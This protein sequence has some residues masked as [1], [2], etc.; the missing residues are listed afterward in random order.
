MLEAFEWNVPADQQHWQRL[1]R[2]LS[3]LKATGV[4]NLWLPPGCKASSPDCN[5]YDIYDLYDLGEFDQKGGWSTKWGSKEELIALSIKAKEVG[6]GLY[7]DAVLNH[8]AAADNVE[9][10]TVVEVDRDDRTQCISNPYEISAW[11]GFEFPGRGEK[12]SKQ[13]YHG[14]H[15]SGTDFNNENHQTAIYRILGDYG[16]GGANRGDAGSENGVYDYLM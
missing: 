11:V 7:W 4:D 16:K 5:G 6:V 3:A 2:Q 12:Y 14:C 1:Q 13:K 8:K 10:C 15:F 9:K